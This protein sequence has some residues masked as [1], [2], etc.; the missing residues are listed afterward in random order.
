MRQREGL[1]CLE[2]AALEAHGGL[3]TELERLAFLEQ[4][5]EA[6]YDAM[7]EAHSPSHA[8]ACYSDAKEALYSAITIAQDLR[9]GEVVERLEARLAHIKAVFRSQFT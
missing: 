6:A 5:A 2:T 8:A 7:Y 1:D 4:Q 3:M 9:A